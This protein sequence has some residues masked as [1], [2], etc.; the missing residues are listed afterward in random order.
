M[1]AIGI[2]EH[3][4]LGFVAEAYILKQEN[5]DYFKVVQT[6][7]IE[8]VEA[9][10]DSLT[11]DQ[12]KIIHLI[13]R[14]NDNSI[15]KTFSKDKKIT[16]FKFYSNM[17]Q[18]LF[19]ERIR[20]YV[21]KRLVEIFNIVKKHHIK[22]FHKADRY[23]KIYVEDEI[24]VQQQNAEA[25]F[26]F[27]RRDN[28]IQYFLSVYHDKKTIKLL[29]KIEIVLSNE[30]CIIVLNNNLYFFNDINAKKLSPFF[31]KNHISV[32]KR[33]E[34]TYF[35]SF[36]LK[37]IKNYRVNA[38]GFEIIDKKPI[39]KILLF[40]ERN[41]KDEYFFMLKFEYDK[42]LYFHKSI[43]TSSVSLS[44]KNG[45]Y[46]FYKYKRDLVWESEQ[47]NFIYNLGLKK[48]DDKV[49]TIKNKFH[50]SSEQQFKSIE[51]IKENFDAIK[52]KNIEIIQ[53]F[54]D[55]K[56]SLKKSL[57]NFKVE[58][59]TDWFDIYAKIYFG[60]IEIPFQK[61]KKYI[62]ANKRVFKLPNGEMAVIPEEWFAKYKNI[63]AFG[64]EEDG[65]LKLNKF[66][67][68]YLAEV[69]NEEERG[70][71]I[72]KKKLGKLLDFF[73]NK[74][75]RTPTIPNNLKAN[76]RDYQKEGFAWLN[77]L[78]IN[79]FGGCLADDMGLGKTIQTLSIIL[80]AM[81]T[82]K[83]KEDQVIQ[84]QLSLFTTGKNISS[85][86]ITS[87][88]VLPKSLIHNWKNEIEKFAPSLRVLI[89]G[90][91][92]RVKMQKNL[93]N[94]DIILMSYG[95]LR[96]DID[97]LK[98]INFFYVVLD[99]SQK[100]KN[101][102]SKIYLAAIQLVAEHH[103]V[104][105]GTPIENS[106]IDIWSQMNFINDGLL[107]SLSFFKYNFIYPI[108]KEND[109]DKQQELKDI[110]SPFIL[111]RTK[112]EVL[113]DLPPFS[114]QTILCEMTAEQKSIYET[115]NSKIRNKIIELQ[116]NGQMRKSSIYILQA[117]N[118]LR[119]IANHPNMLENFNDTNSGKFDEIIE[120]IE[121]ITSANQKILLFSSF[122]KH[123]QIFA[124]YFEQKN[125]K[126]SLL[127]GSTSKREEVIDNFQNNSD[128]KL[129]L[130]SIKAGGVGL[131][132]TSASYVFILDPWWNPAIENQAISRAHRMGQ[133]AKVMV[134]RFIT[135]DTIEEK[136]RK[137]QQKKQKL[138]DN[139][140]GK[141]NIF[142]QLSEKN[143]VDLF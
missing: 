109:E 92:Q 132:L 26:N 76:L 22:V 14:Y 137:L 121:I 100:I 71:Q 103:L 50:N 37:S 105:T 51:W 130:I 45:N 89:Y 32:P 98:E 23:N 27:H 110:I 75:H 61:L 31:T 111:R 19:D 87:L 134:Y 53:N 125:L 17:S 60:D 119:Q 81:E 58:Q 141:N 66:H 63:F 94:Y 95:V 4:S 68:N 99:E 120:K 114:E 12:I 67:A 15:F 131:N 54:G 127:T 18:K 82:S 49:L 38:K 16:A 123:L 8:D 40:T 86:E 35:E 107:G 135:E 11:K 91:T 9:F 104:L 80:K 6:A 39:R 57:I 2:K 142:T 33:I 83:I 42:I 140:I 72:N 46:T 47:L 65:I 52:S 88:I 117:L 143:I 44:E 113:K 116:E 34:K 48:Y 133:K 10:S 3:S 79:G 29:D 56:Y 129:F 69:E 139:L 1:F 84:N 7:H 28:E 43:N 25:L 64:R 24:F 5:S 115:E 93:Q 41:F 20:P 136:I 106:L 118:K 85:Q 70:I 102:S 124:D 126:Y 97:F 21:E 108:D 74:K 73:G 77:A 59:K 78:N 90:G 101:P 128:N 62:L 122:V 55:T 96:N 112:N 13:N 30:P 138:A 36:I